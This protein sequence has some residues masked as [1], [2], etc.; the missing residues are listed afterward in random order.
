MPPGRGVDVSQMGR[1]PR[2]SVWSFLVVRGAESSLGKAQPS[3]LG[4][5]NASWT[6]FPREPGL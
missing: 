3:P 1:Q 4:V 6:D 2:L 5:S